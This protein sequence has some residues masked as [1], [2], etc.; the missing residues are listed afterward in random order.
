MLDLETLST[1]KNAVILSIGAVFFDPIKGKVGESWE[2]LISI[3]SCLEKGLEIDGNTLNWWVQQSDKARESLFPKDCKDGARWPLKEALKDLINWIESHIP[4]SDIYD[5]RVWGCGSDFDNANL[6]NA[7]R[8]CGM[9][10]FWK[11]YNNRCFRT[12][13]ELYPE[14]IPPKREEDEILHSARHDA[15]YQAKWAIKIFKEGRKV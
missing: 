11:F 10:S 2:K 7:Y 1:S 14:I 6:D 5:I 12:L 15:I 8:K 3:N 13:K 9:E 4:I